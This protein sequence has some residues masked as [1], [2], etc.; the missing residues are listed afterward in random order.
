MTTNVLTTGQM[1]IPAMEKMAWKKVR[2]R[3]RVVCI[4]RGSATAT[5]HGFNSFCY[6]NIFKRCVYSGFSG[7]DSGSPVFFGL[8]IQIDAYA[9]RKGLVGALKENYRVWP[10]NGRV[11]TTYWLSWFDFSSGLLTE[12]P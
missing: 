1:T 8:F 2:C 11:G 9:A 4:D 12:R 7:S 6:G 10:N 3:G 5:D